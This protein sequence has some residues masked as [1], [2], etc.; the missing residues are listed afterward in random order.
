MES[1]VAIQM[2]LSEYRKA[3]EALQMWAQYKR[4]NFRLINI[5]LI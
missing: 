5:K 4:I 2:W 1:R 3:L